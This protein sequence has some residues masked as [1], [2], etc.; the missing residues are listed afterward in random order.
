MTRSNISMIDISDKKDVFRSAI[1]EGKIKLKKSTIKLIKE[2][3]I[4]KGDVLSNAE[5]AAINAVKKTPDFIFLAHPIPIMGVNVQ[6]EIDEPNAYIKARV[7]VKSQG[8]TGVE[9][10]AIMGV[11]IAL[12]TIWDMTKYVE[13]D[14]NGQYPE[15]EIVEIKVIKKIKGS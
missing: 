12:L 13:K 7:E 15:T 8:K 11:Q 5:L 1:A 4:K 9:L 6:F 10:E 14:E 3:K 2:K